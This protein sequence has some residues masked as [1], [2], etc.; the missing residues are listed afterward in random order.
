ALLEAVCSLGG[1][2]LDTAQ[3]R[4]AGEQT[5]AS[6]EEQVSGQAEVEAVVHALEEQY[7][8]YVA[9]QGRGSLLAA[10]TGELPSA[11]ELGAELERFLA[12]EN[13]RRG[14]GDG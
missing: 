12:E 6:I 10:D 4:A 3:L 7:D 13:E 1:L 9:G 5:R 2:S 8:A 14:R 11:D